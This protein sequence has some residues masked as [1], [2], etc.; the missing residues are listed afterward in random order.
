MKKKR[1]VYSPMQKLHVLGYGEGTVSGAAGLGTLVRVDF[2]SGNSQHFKP[3]ELD[4][5]VVPAGSLIQPTSEVTEPKMT[6]GQLRA[7]LAN[8]PDAD[9]VVIVVKQHNKH[10]GRHL[11]IISTI[12]RS[13]YEYWVSNRQGAVHISVHLPAPAI[14]SKWPED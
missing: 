14:I 10:Y 13:A 4:K 7:A 2:A 12:H 11:N 1:T 5:L 3:S 6:V 9:E 8:S